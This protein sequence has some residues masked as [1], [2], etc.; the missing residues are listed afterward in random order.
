MIDVSSLK[1]DALMYM[2]P[3]PDEVALVEM[4]QKHG[5]EMVFTNDNQIQIQHKT[6][7]FDNKEKT[8]IWKNESMMEFKV[9]KRIE[10]NSDRKRMSILLQD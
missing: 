8:E 7:D 9:F 3:S 1:S 4:A 5:F 6:L 2:G 10:F